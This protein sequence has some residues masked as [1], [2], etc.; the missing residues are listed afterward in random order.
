VRRRPRATTGPRWWLSPTGAA[1]NAYLTSHFPIARAS[2]SLEFARDGLDRARP[3][4][5]AGG[6]VEIAPG[7]TVEVELTW[8]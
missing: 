1:S 7:A 3:L 6:S 8:D 5:P 4:L 2:R